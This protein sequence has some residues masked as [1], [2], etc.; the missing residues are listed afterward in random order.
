MTVYSESHTVKD[1]PPPLLPRL[2]S[3]GDV[4]VFK[5]IQ[6]KGCRSHFL[7]D[8]ASCCQYVHNTSLNTNAL[9]DLAPTNLVAT[10]P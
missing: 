8:L 1:N 7:I 5:P 6:A 9:S 10:E 2:T 4:L 3:C